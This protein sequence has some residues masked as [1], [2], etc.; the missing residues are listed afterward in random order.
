MTGAFFFLSWHDR[1]VS[2]FPRSR[3]H[4]PAVRVT[5]MF[6]PYNNIADSR[7]N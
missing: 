1:H 2:V 3:P 4:R 6:T 7:L 5:D